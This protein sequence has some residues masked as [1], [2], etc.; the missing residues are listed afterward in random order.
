MSAGCHHHHHHGKGTEQALNVTLAVNVVLTFAKWTAF[1]FTRS[2]SLFAE[3]VHSTFDTMNPL[4]LWIGHRRSRRP[5]DDQHP[6]GHTRE[7][8]FWPLIAAIMMFAFGAGF[9]AYRGIH[10]LIVGHV[11]EM[12][13]WAAVI[14]VGALIGEGVSLLMSRRALKGDGIHETKNTT[15]LALV[16]ENFVDMLGVTLALAGYGLF[17]LT[18]QAVWDAIFSIAIAC[19]LAYASIYL[20]RRNMSLITGETADEKTLEEIRETALGSPFVMRVTGLTVSMTG[21]EDMC[22]R[23]SVVLDAPKL[24]DAYM[25]DGRAD[26]T[27]AE[28]IYWVMLRTVLVRNDIKERVLRKYPRMQFIHI[29]CS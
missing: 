1:I 3:A 6:M 13:W 8:F 28:A 5:K 25:E 23:M 4:V 24:A 15:A 2:S 12:H 18:G 22:C 17:L 16:F 19:L 27:G 9:T 14:M 29:E 21:P 20:I 11:P 7:A 26:G 10:S